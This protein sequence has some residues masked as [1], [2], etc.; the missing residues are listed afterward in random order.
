MAVQR[1]AWRLRYGLN[2][3]DWLDE[4][5][6]VL[7]AWFAACMLAALEVLVALWTRLDL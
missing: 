3:W 6:E 4:V 1:D 2:T 5:T 7:E